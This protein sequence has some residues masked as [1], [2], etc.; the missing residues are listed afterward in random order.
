M[1]IIFLFVCVHTQILDTPSL[2]AEGSKGN[3]KNI[4]KDKPSQTNAT[5]SCC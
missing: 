3:K 2:L 4:F 1:T 5:S